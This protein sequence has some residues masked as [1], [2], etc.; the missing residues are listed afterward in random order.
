MTIGSDT[1]A[2]VLT[3]LQPPDI[4][5]VLT[6][7]LSRDWRQTFT[8]QTELWRVLYVVEPFKAEINDGDDQDDMD[9]SASSY[10]FCSLGKEVQQ[11][12]SHLPEKYRLLNTSFVRCMKYLSQIREDA[13]NGRAPSFI[14]YRVAGTKKQQILV[15]QNRNLQDCLAR[16]R[17]AS[18]DD[19]QS[20]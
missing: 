2:H 13:L 6:M 5:D 17:G 14:D 16:A 3:F 15:G 20:D 12:A 11:P 7:P 1:M 8:F 10:S 4:L 19:A 9:D 18:K